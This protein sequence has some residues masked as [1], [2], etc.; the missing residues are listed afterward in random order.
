MKKIPI[1]LMITSALFFAC[2]TGISGELEKK[3]GS[4]KEQDIYKNIEK[5]RGEHI[6]FLQQLIQ[7]QKGGE[8]EVQSLVAA[9]F[10]ELGCHVETLRIKPT[11]L[12]FKYQFAAARFIPDKKR[13]S[14]VGTYPGTGKG[15][16]ILL[17]AHPDS[18]DVTSIEEWTHNPFAG[19][20]E[21]GKIYG[22][23]VADD[24][25][26]VAVMTQALAALLDAGLKPGGDIILC[27]TPAKKN[28]QGVIALLSRGYRADA[29][30][31]LHPAES[32]VGMREIKAIASGLLTL[33]IKIRGKSPETTEPGKTAFAHLGV[34]PISKAN[35]II[36]ALNKLDEQRGKR[37]VHK[38]LEEKVGR[39]TNLLVSYISSGDR[40]ALTQV[41]GECTMG[42]SVTFPP[43]EQLKK[44]QKEIQH[45]IEEA[46]EKDPWLRRYQPEIEWIFGS[47][48]VEVPVGHPLYRTVSMSIQEV[49][50]ENPFVNPLHSASD[51]RNPNL[52][53]DI[54]T[55]GYGPLGGNLSQNGRHD[56]WVDVSDYIRA[57][58]VTAKTIW[59]WGK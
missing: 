7:A 1:F 38:A 58:K 55:V 29:S 48:G 45:C 28:A 23:G 10:K 19:E 51:I 21:G 3:P 17:F 40:D 11:N 15:R 54:P 36:Q 59:E 56:E 42:I 41:P 12:K 16:S 44:V 27:S 25:S 43:G 37:I 57:I 46:A 5:K 2:G 9:K 33:R 49:T 35:L 47:Q 26:G 13:I 18:E 24:L 39:S 53:S 50:G 22:W 14:V 32:G 6:A 34:N 52:F 31:Y 8:E 4:Q 20:I 30:I